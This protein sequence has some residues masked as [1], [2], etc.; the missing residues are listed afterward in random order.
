MRLF[1]I[2]LIVP[3][4]L[5]AQSFQKEKLDSVFAR[6]DQHG[7]F[8][9]SVAMFKGE[10]LLYQ[11]A[12]GYKESVG[13]RK[14]D[15]H[16]KYRIGSIT[17]TFTAALVMKA[18]E[19]GKLSLDDKLSK[20]FPTV[21]KADSINIRQMLGHR[22]GIENFTNAVDYLSW[23]TKPHTK[24][25]VLEKIVK[26]NSRFSPGSSFEYSNSAYFL[27][28]LIL[29][30]VSK[31]SYEELLQKQ[32]IKPLKLSETSIG[33]KIDPTKN[34]CRSFVFNG[35]WILSPETDMSV[36]FSAGSIISTPTDICR[37]AQQLFEGKLLSAASLKEMQTFQDNVGLGL[38]QFQFGTKKSS[39]HTGGIDGFSTVY[40]YFPEDKLSFTLFCNGSN[41]NNNDLSIILLSAAFGKEVK[42]PDFTAK[43]LTD[44]DLQSYVGVY[45]SKQ[46][47]LKL[48]FTSKN[49]KLVS[50][51]TGQIAF[52]LDAMGNHVFTKDQFGIRLTFDPVKKQ[53]VL[54]QGAAT[55]LFE[56]E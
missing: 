19:A 30:K 49:G 43:T 1:F 21:P 17:K 16:T 56:K 48:T 6:L 36:P 20:W 54:T 8:M 18:V 14:S 24:T 52:E 32:I 41:Y 51:A 3:S 13:G 7:K 46:I 38:F 2:L 15:I 35:N 5:T 37:F 47:P 40:G 27:L 10:E 50:Q 53:V 11:H 23:N 28:G 22:S 12:I 55:L 39:G 45:G 31:Q 29:E 42:V 4:L 44:A 34:E 9:G 26:G 25:Q 33:G